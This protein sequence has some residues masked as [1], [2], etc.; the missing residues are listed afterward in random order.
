MKKIII[1]ILFTLVFLPSTS[2]GASLFFTSDKNE[3]DE[4]EEFLVQVFLDTESVPINAVEGV[5]KFPTEFLNLK[6]IR[7]G[8]SAINF[9][10]DKPTNNNT[11]EVPFSGITTGG[12]SGSSRFL[13]GLVF[14]AKKIGQGALYLNNLQVLQNDGLGTKIST[15]TNPFKFSVLSE[16]SGPRANLKIEDNVAPESFTPFVASDP[17]IFDGQYFLVFSTVDKGVGVDFFEIREG[18]WG[19]YVKAESPH[20][21]S[22]Q[23]L[24]KNIYVVAFDK[25]G[26]ERLVVIDAKNPD[27]LF[28]FGIILGIISIICIAYFRKKTS[29]KKLK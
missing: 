13:F 6:E 20:L 16:G 22:D 26:N 27:L 1:T 25:N 3:F 9:W 8:N 10:L 2:F 15:K 23:S 12:L 18:F 4:N 5:L 19:K 17:S 7:D 24:T 11:G 28:R 14:E 21:L 29:K